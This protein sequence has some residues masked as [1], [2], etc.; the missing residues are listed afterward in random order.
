[1]SVFMGEGLALYVAARVLRPACVA[2]C[3]TGTGFAAACLALGAPDAQ[4]FTVDTYSEGGAGDAG[5][6]IVRAWTTNLGL[7]NLY[8]LRGSVP[9][10][11]AAI[12]GRKVDLAAFD[13][14]G[15][16]DLPWAE[17]AVVANH[18]NRNIVG[19]RPFS[20]MVRGGSWLTFSF[21]D[22]G[23]R[24]LVRAEVERLVGPTD[25]N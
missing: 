7:S 6:A 2:D 13:P 22:A 21:Q 12:C 25:A 9:E 5:E 4:V 23:K 17:G 19:E 14:E 11:N 10:M 20:F 8:V 1:L 18:D 3:F 16:H 24:D 15:N